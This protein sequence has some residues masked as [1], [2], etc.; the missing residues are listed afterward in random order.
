MRLWD[1]DSGRPL[2]TFKGHIDRISSLAFSPDGTTLASSSF[3]RTVKLWDASRPSQP[4]VLTSQSLMSFG[5]APHCVAFSPDSRQI[6]SGHADHAVR[7]WEAATGRLRLTLTGHDK[8]VAGV[9]FS[10]SGQTIASASED[11]TVRLWDA[12]TGQLRFRLAQ[13]TGPVK[14]AKF[15]PDGR[16]LV[17]T[18]DDGTLKVWDPATGRCVLSIPSQTG[19]P[20]SRYTA[21]MGG[22]SRRPS[23]VDASRLGTPRPVT[24]GDIGGHPDRA[25]SAFSP[26]DRASP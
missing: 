9:A 26:A 16:R 10:P 8:S 24:R 21:P 3:D 5:A 1:I 15:S 25:Q 6:A 2:Q 19:E 17:S 18:S 4:R 22:R 20:E 7:I 11:N 23:A 14:S 13:H 12:A